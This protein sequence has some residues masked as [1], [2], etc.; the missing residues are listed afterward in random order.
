MKTSKVVHKQ[1]VR[2]Y[3]IDAYDHVNNASYIS[4]FEDQREMLLRAEGLDYD[5]LAKANAWFV[6]VKIDCDFISAALPSEEVEITTRLVRFGRTSVTWRQSVRALADGRVCAR[7]RN[8]MCFADADDEPTPIPRLS[9]SA[10]RSRKKVTSGPTPKEASVPEL[11][12]IVLV[13]DALDA[14]TIAARAARHRCRSVVISRDR[15]EL[16]AALG[17]VP[18]EVVD[19]DDSRAILDALL[20]GPNLVVLDETSATALESAARSAS[21]PCLRN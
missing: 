11:T 2:S 18:C 1:R 3:E 13:S 15:V 7:A 21:V 17:R 4:W 19:A 6:I 14:K 16:R 9:W 20:P 5:Q 12:M 10:S 8:V